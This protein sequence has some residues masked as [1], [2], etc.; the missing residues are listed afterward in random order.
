MQRLRN[1]LRKAL[2]YPVKYVRNASRTDRQRGSELFRAVE[3]NKIDNVK[4]ILSTGK[5]FFVNR[6]GDGNNQLR[7]A[8][9]LNRSP[10]MVAA[11]CN[12]IMDEINNHR[13][14]VDTLL[15]ILGSHNT[16]QMN[17]LLI[18]IERSPQNIGN[19]LEL[20]EKVG[21]VDY[22][23][24]DKK[25]SLHLA[26]KQTLVTSVKKLIELHADVN[27]KDEDGVTPLLVAAEND[28]SSE[29]T[30]ILNILLNN[31]A[32]INETDNDKSTAVI[33]ASQYNNL[34][35]LE[36]LLKHKPN[37]DKQDI[38]GNTALLIASTK[39]YTD[40]VEALTKAGATVDIV[41][42]END[43]ALSIAVFNQHEKVIEHL[44]K[45]GANVNHKNKDGNEIIVLAL[46]KNDINIIKLL[47][48]N[49]ADKDAAI[50]YATDKGDEELL[51]IV[52][53][54]I[55][56]YKG[57]AQGDFDK[58]QSLFEDEKSIENISFC[59]L[60]LFYSERGSEERTNNKGKIIRDYH[61][62]WLQGHRCSTNTPYYHKELYD[63]YYN[64]NLKSGI[65]WCTICNRIG[66]KHAHVKK[67]TGIDNKDP[68]LEVSKDSFG[69]EKECL[70]EG[71]GG[72][73]EKK[74]RFARLFQI[75][76]DLQEKVGKITAQ[77]A[78]EQ[79]V[80]YTW[81]TKDTS[82]DLMIEKDK[83]GKQKIVFPCKLPEKVNSNS[84]DKKVTRPEE[85]KGDEYPPKQNNRTGECAV[86]LEPGSDK[87]PLY[88]FQHHKQKNG[89]YMDHTSWFH[90]NCIKG[91]IEAYEGD[92]CL[93]Q[94]T[95]DCNGLMWPEELNGLK[96]YLKSDGTPYDDWSEKV[97]EKMFNESY[98]K[99]HVQSGGDHEFTI[100]KPMKG[101]LSC[102]VKRGGGRKTRRGRKGLR[103]TKRR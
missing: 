46:K 28:D 69:G 16:T 51:A 93:C 64:L 26:C 95:D 11:I 50:K 88:Q 27:I 45:A 76:C 3:E 40:V 70:A 5:I 67:G 23:N 58:W 74:R 97:Y 17:T 31:K 71:G 57:F 87:T 83:N 60:C 33:L 25:T 52:E 22:T 7:L 82:K 10:E 20:A 41:N 15:I 35:N 30:D 94:A 98:A 63:I 55:R 80:E 14:T 54:R 102:A 62:R 56:M 34:A 39:G 8:L 47:L 12:K 72:F 101:D 103:Q 99:H 32:D 84:N 77:E 96:G 91:G 37:L 18:A 21:G 90:A 2:T 86:C 61:C 66:A 92:K 53:G 43:T 78:L 48:A 75:I 36:I 13:M 44:I 4:R 1:R 38:N 73:A 85:E 19:I 68:Q 100:L 24:D 79:M 6:S 9:H 81:N 89:K 42:K 29:N 59:P 49:G 65:T